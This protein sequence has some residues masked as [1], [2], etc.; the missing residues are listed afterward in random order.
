MRFPQRSIVLLILLLPIVAWAVVF[1]QKGVTLQ[2]FWEE[3]PGQQPLLDQLAVRVHSLPIPISSIQT[4]TLQIGVVFSG[5]ERDVENRAWLAAFK[6]RMQILRIDYRLDVFYLPSNYSAN[7]VV[8]VFDAI[9]ASN[10]DY[11]VADDVTEYLRPE[12]EQILVQRTPKMILTNVSTPF[13]VWRFHPPLIYI[14]VDSSQS[15]GRLASYLDRRLSKN[16]S[17]DVIAV[18]DSYLYDSRCSTFVNALETIG[19]EVRDYYIVPD[20]QIDGYRAAMSSLDHGSVYLE[21]DSA[22]QEQFIFSCSAEVSA[23]VWEALNDAQVPQTYTN[24]WSGKPP[25]PSGTHN[26]HLLVT[27]LGMHDNKAIATA[28]VIKADIESRLLPMVYAEPSQLITQDMDEQTLNIMYEQAFM[29]S[30]PL[31]PL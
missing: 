1:G 22:Q 28:E 25:Y 7:D 17:I 3:N 13:N 23:G 15:M 2:R 16:A 21:G 10:F 12:F 31:W 26:P 20:S 14:G 19:R 9:R 24:S 27:V 8:R 11:L 29:Y 30:R 6:R 4:N 18:D 5:M